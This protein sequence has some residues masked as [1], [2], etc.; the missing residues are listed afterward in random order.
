MDRRLDTYEIV[1]III[2]GKSF[3]DDEMIV[4][5]A[6]GVTVEDKKIMLGFIQAATENAS[7]CK[8]FLNGLLDRGL[9]IEEGALCIMDGSKGIRKAVEE[10]FGKP[11]PYSKVS[12][13]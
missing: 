7:V 12:V 2:D 1:A 10:I 8:N 11:H 9:K 6:L 13:A 5:V 4:I 3:K